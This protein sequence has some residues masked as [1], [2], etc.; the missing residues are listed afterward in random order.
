VQVEP[1]GFLLHEYN[2]GG[3]RFSPSREG[4]APRWIAYTSDET[5]RHEVYIRDFPGGSH[6][7]RISN[8][9]GVLPQWRRDGRE[10]FYIAPDGT[11]MAVAV[12]PDPELELGAPQ[13]LF[14][15]GLQLRMYD[16]WM[17][18]YSPTH[19]GQR[20]LLNCALPKALPESI[21]AV[22]PR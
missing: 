21:T 7:W 15:T 16:I 8:H 6:K 4:E 18:Q 1:H 12:N 20:F 9:G 3:A 5:G 2:E 13:K 19:D 10:L 17:N 22:I 11:L 14:V